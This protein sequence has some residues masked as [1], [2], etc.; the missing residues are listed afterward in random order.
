MT[1][2][3][4]DHDFGFGRAITHMHHAQNAA[5]FNGM[6]LEY[7]LWECGYGISNF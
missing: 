3:P 1:L 7:G 4:G 5:D 6:S 2:N